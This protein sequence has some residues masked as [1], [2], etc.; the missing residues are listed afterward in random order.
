MIKQNTEPE[1]G[2]GRAFIY[3]CTRDRELFEQLEILSEQELTS[4]ECEC[5]VAIQHDINYNLNS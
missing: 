2:Y 3:V 4:L 1:Q 5:E